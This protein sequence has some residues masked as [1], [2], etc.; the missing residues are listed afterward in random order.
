VLLGSSC[1]AVLVVVVLQRRRREQGL[2]E[3]ARTVDPMAPAAGV[4]PAPPQAR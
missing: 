2:A 4:R 1:C 3:R